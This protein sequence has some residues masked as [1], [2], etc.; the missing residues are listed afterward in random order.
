[1]VGDALETDVTGGITLGC[2]TV[3]VI[4]DGIHGAQVAQH[5][6]QLKEKGTAYEEAVLRVL[7]NFND[8]NENSASTS[9]MG[10]EDSKKIIVPTFAVKSFRWS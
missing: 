1:M 4:R 3:W 6:E 9:K 8:P 2:N 5:E 7:E 10:Q